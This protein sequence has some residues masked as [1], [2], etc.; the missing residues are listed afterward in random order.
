MFYPKNQIEFETF[1]NTDDKC[2]SYL[3]KIKYDNGYR[4]E[5]CSGINYWKNKRGVFVCKS[6][7]SETTVTAGTVFHGSKIPIHLLFRFLWFLV[8]QKNGISAKSLQRILGFSRYE[9]VWTWLHKFRQI[10]VLPNRGKLKGKVEVDET[11]IGGV[12]TGKRGRGAEGKVLVVVAVELIGGFTGRVRMAII[13]MADRKNINDFVKNNIEEGST[14]VTDSWKGYTDLERMKYKHEIV[15]KTITVNDQ[16]L[17]PHVHKIASLLKRWLLGTHQN[18]TSVDYLNYYL[19]EFTFR[20]N[21][22][23]SNSRGLLF[24][25]LL[26]QAILHKPIHEIKS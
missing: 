8:L 15:T 23:K 11:F 1:F 19:D 21:R 10:M 24:Y 12:K 17:T 7:K 2:L 16:N 26:Q 25:V 6:C 18:F 3:E 5:L 13:E 4:C 22:R 20:Y 9:T 14:I